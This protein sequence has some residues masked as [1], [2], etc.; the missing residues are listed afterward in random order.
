[1][2]L[3]TA[4]RVFSMAVTGIV[5]FKFSN[6]PG[7]SIGAAALSAGVT[8]EAVATKFMVVNVIK[9]LKVKISESEP[10]TFSSIS[11][12]YYPLALTALL[13]L[14]VQPLVTFF[15]GSSKMAIESLAVLPVIYSLVFL[16]RSIAL[17]YQEVGLALIGEDR[18]GYKKLRN[19]ALYIALSLVAL[20]FL[21]GFTPL[22]KIWFEDVSGLSHELSLFSILPYQIIAVMPALTIFI[23]FQRAIVMIS[24]KTGSITGATLAEVGGI[25]L[26]MIVM[27]KFF[28]TA[29]AVAA[30]S[31]FIIGR[32]SA[33]FYLTW[34]YNAAVKSFN[35]SDKQV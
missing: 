12:F 1:V 28:N 19:F 30:T 8:S 23:S 20:S 35:L 10:L 18:S 26:V 13:S 9:N 29:G 31:A 2:A 25:I 22:S 11:I 15:I 3:G 27:I 34:P 4:V 5:L 33:N 17:S 7:S 6:L 16:F 32:L 14:G 21:I 24:K